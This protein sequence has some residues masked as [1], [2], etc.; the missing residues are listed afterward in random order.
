MRTRKYT[1]IAFLIGV[2]MIVIGCRT[3]SGGSE[4]ADRKT[5]DRFATLPEVVP[6]HGTPPSQELISLGRML[7]FEP[8]LSRSQ[9]VSCNSCHPLARYG[10]DGQPTSM[11]Y[12]GQH[13]N[14]N[15]PSVYNAAGQSIQFWD[16]R[17]PDVEEQAKGPLLNPVEMAMPSAKAVVQ[18][19]KSMPEYVAAFHR[20]FPKDRNPLT[21]DHATEAIGAFERKLLTPSRWDRFLQGEEATLTADEKGGFNI[22][23]D[24]G[25]SGCHEGALVGG[26]TL[27][28][29]GGAKPYPD[30]SDPGRYNVTKDEGDRM[31]FKVPSLRNVAMTGPYFHN[32]RVATLQEAVTQMAEYQLGKKLSDG[33][34]EAIVTWLESLTGELPAD[35]I[36]EPV[37]PK[38]TPRTPKPVTAG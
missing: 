3:R 33:Q 14:R 34:V 38:S 8:R 28:R 37:L 35:Y 21:F 6:A 29:L 11:G 5:L 16:G 15:S 31:F 26:T 24:A 27:Q 4:I 17:A 2:G 30:N 1:I 12:K 22:F 19:L 10:V 23:V 9:T 18:V 13:G 25:C 7:Y 36:K 20:A 32:G